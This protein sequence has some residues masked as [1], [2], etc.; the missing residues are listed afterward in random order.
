MT[1]LLFLGIDGGGT[2]C[3]ARL[4]D[5]KGTLLGEGTGGPSNLR[6]DPEL[7]W[8]SLLTACREALAQAGLQESDLERI[9]AGMGAA[10]AGQTS[11]VERLLSHAH[12]FASFEIETDAHTAWLGAFNGGDG[13]ILIVGTGSCGYGGTSGQCH[14]VGGWGYEISDEGSGASIGR[15]LLRRCIWAYDGRT[16]STPLS[17]AVL[18]EF[19]NDLE[20]LVDWV[21]RARPADYGRYAPLV[22]QHAE[23]RDPL[24]IAII[25][26]AAAGLSA[27]G[28]RLLD[29]GAPA[30]C[31]FGGL[32]APLR[33]WLSPPVQRTIAEPMADA[34]DGAILLARMALRERRP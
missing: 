12:P 30:I 29:L 23:R 25:E 1:D 31:L 4:R 5:A 24:G 26:D 14:Y 10:G 21:G 9:H 2:K 22:L 32:S 20:I 17:E 18:A 8:N 11:A 6:L 33:P 28:M 16:A 19:K 13:A 7:V 27:I 3:R 34:L 15:E